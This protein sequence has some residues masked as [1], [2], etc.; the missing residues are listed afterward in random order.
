MPYLFDNNSKYWLYIHIPK[1]GGTS[2]E[3]A[4]E[5]DI[6]TDCF[7]KGSFKGHNSLTDVKKI[8][9]QNAMDFNKFNTFTTVRNPW[10]WYISHFYYLRAKFLKN[11]AGFDP[12]FLDEEAYLV[13]DEF[14]KFIQFIYDNRN[15][16]VFKN[17]GLN[18]RKYQQMLEWST[19]DGKKVDHIIKME[20]MIDPTIL[21]SIGLNIMLPTTKKNTSKHKHYTDYYNSHTMKLVYDMHKDDIDFFEYEF[22]SY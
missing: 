4:I 2:I 5:Q 15:T 11:G 12:D 20:D 8:L 7:M 19:A 21:S 16:L 17:N 22:S 9:L 1:T 13:R 10:S 18:T 3:V 6:N 14:D